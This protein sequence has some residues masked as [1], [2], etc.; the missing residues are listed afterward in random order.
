MTFSWRSFVTV[1]YGE[2]GDEH[3]LR[4][5]DLC[6][7]VWRVN[8]GFRLVIPPQPPPNSTNLLRL[9]APQE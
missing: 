9:R 1:P 5:A 3:S 8:P 2:L 4:P 6:P 7:P